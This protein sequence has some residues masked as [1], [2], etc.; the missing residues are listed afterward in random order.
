MVW[1]V[2]W[3]WGFQVFLGYLQNIC[4]IPSPTQQPQQIPVTSSRHRLKNNHPPATETSVLPISIN[5]HIAAATCIY[6][7]LCLCPISMLG[8]EIFIFHYLPLP[9]SSFSWLNETPES[10]T[11]HL[12]MLQTS[13]KMKQLM[14]TVKFSSCSHSPNQHKLIRAG[15]GFRS[16]NS[17]NVITWNLTDSKIWEFT[18]LGILCKQ[19]TQILLPPK[20]QVLLQASGEMPPKLNIKINGS[21]MKTNQGKTSLDLGAN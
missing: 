19:P 17:P 5:T 12:P 4:S 8:S 15:P 3:M 18:Q 6:I 20:H 2:P 16:L 1:E 21:A 7:L 10:K 9:S 14:T 13:P 11:K